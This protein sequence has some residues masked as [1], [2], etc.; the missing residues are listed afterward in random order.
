ML[1]KILSWCHLVVGIVYDS[2]ILVGVHILVHMQYQ[3]H[4]EAAKPQQ[5]TFLRP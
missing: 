2:Q 5:R 4:F 1:L 3:L